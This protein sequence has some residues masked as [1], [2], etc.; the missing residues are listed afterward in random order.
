MFLGLN[1]DKWK[2]EGLSKNCP[3]TCDTATINGGEAWRFVV[4]DNR[5]PH[6]IVRGAGADVIENAIKDAGSSL[7]VAMT[8][9][10][11]AFRSVQDGGTDCFATVMMQREGDNLSGTGKYEFYR[12][13]AGQQRIKLVNGSFEVVIPMDRAIWTGVFGRPGGDGPWSEMLRNLGKIGVTLGGKSDFGHG[14][15]GDGKLYMTKFEIV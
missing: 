3:A 5:Q 13:W 6:Y 8:I 4:K 7:N 9:S 1:G 15:K 2:L 14:I 12:L 10:E 11:A